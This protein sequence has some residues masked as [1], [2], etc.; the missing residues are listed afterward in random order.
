MNKDQIIEALSYVEDPDLK[1]DLVSLGMIQD[2]SINGAEVAFDLVLTTPACPMKESIVNACKNAIYTMV[3]SEAIVKINITSNVQQSRD[4]QSVL[5]GIKNII[6]VAS[7]L[8]NVR[9][10]INF[11]NCL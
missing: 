3:N 11:Y 1:K 8:L 2:L 9:R 5:S 6:A 4:D 10:Y 7:A